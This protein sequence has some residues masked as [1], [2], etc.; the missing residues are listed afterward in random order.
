MERFPRWILITLAIVVIALAM[1]Y[2]SSI[3]A[4]MLVAGIL[5]LIGN[6]IATF[7]K[8]R[9]VGKW[10]VPDWLAALLT[11]GL[12][13]LVALAVIALFIPLVISQA[14]ILSTVDLDNVAKTFESSLA[15]VEDFAN[16]LSLNANEEVKI[17]DALSE[18]LKRIVS[19]TNVSNILNNLFGVMGN[20]F[21][22]S[23]SITFMLFFFLKEEGL[24]FNIIKAVTPSKY[25][26]Q[27][28]HILLSS[29][30]LL[31]KYF[32]GVA[33]QITVITIWVGLGLHLVGLENALL[34]GFLAGLFN[35]IPYVGPIL[36]AFVGVL[37]GVISHLDAGLSTELLPLIFGIML[38]FASMQALDNFVL[39]PFV[40]GGSVNAHPLEVFIVI[41]AAGSSLGVT[42]MILAVPAYTVLRIIA[43]EFL[44]EFRIVKSLTKDI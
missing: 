6:P 14:K 10:L 16:G 9:K 17:T 11:M 8:K 20:L 12:M 4:Y 43:K 1:W 25:S 41:L 2:F 33:T 39:Q 35:I 32:I 26:H 30:K 42:G 5:S 28:D 34:I 31:T 21:I 40:L 27:I 22:A 37:L 44:G 29:Q 24:F 36:G 38:V 15:W 23:F 7:L 3:I 19:F 13:S 18:Q